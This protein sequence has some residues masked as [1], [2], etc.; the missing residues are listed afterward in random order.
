MNNLPM[1]PPGYTRGQKQ[2]TGTLDSQGGTSPSS[3]ITADGIPPKKRKLRTKI[4]L[5][6]RFVEPDPSRQDGLMR[7]TKPVEG[8]V[9]T[10][11]TTK[12]KD[13]NISVPRRSPV[14]NDYFNGQQPKNPSSTNKDKKATT[15]SQQQPIRQKWLETYAKLQSYKSQHNT[16]EINP[17]ETTDEELITLSKWITNQKNTYNKWKKGYQQTGM[18]DEKVKLLKELGMEFSLGWDDMYD[19]LV[20]HHRKN[21]K[22][23]TSVKKRNEITEK[24]D[25]LGAEYDVDIIYPQLRTNDP[26][27]YAW[28]VRQYKALGRH[29]KGHS[30]RL[31]D[32][33]AKKLLALGLGRASQKEGGDI[34]NRGG[35]KR[36]GGEKERKSSEGVKSN[37]SNSS[38][39]SRKKKKSPPPSLK[40]AGVAQSEGKQEEEE[41][42]DDDDFFAQHNDLCEVCANPG[43]LLCCSTCNLVFHLQCTRPHLNVEPPDDWSCS[44][45]IANDGEQ[46]GMLAKEKCRVAQEAIVEMECTRRVLKEK[47]DKEKIFGVDEEEKEVER[48]EVEVK[49]EQEGEEDDEMDK[50]PAAVPTPPLPLDDD[51]DT[52]FNIFQSNDEESDPIMEG[53]QMNDHVMS[54][55]AA[56]ATAAI[57]KK[58]EVPKVG[59]G[60]RVLFDKDDVYTAKIIEVNG[61]G[62]HPADGYEDEPTYD[63]RIRYDDDGVIEDVK[64]PDDDITLIPGRVG[65]IKT[66]KSAGMRAAVDGSKTS[67]N[68]P[69]A[70]TTTNPSGSRILSPGLTP[71]ASN[72]QVANYNLC[73][74]KIPSKDDP[75][76]E[77]FLTT[78]HS[79]AD[80]GLVNALHDIVRRDVFEVRRTMSGKI[81]FQCGCCKHVPRRERA[82]LSIVAPQNVATIYRSFVRFMMNHVK[83][84]KH[85][86]SSV[87]RLQCH[88]TA[89]DMRC[90]SIDSRRGGIKEYWVTSAKRLGYV[91][92]ESGKAI[93]YCPPGKV[94]PSDGMTTLSANTFKREEHRAKERVGCRQS[95][96]KRKGTQR[97][98]DR[99]LDEDNAA[100]ASPAKRPRSR[101]ECSASASMAPRSGEVKDVAN[102][103]KAKEGTSLCSTK[104]CKKHA[105]FAGVCVSHGAMQRI[106][107]TSTSS[108]ST[109]SNSLQA[110]AE[111]NQAGQKIAASTPLPEYAR[112]ERKRSPTS[113]SDIDLLPS[114]SD[115]YAAQNNHVMEVASS[116]KSYEPLNADDALED[117]LLNGS[118]NLDSFVDM[119]LDELPDP[120]K[121]EDEP[122]A[123]SADADAGADNDFAKMWLG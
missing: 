87:R 33:Q 115:E 30:T 59:M 108:N 45:C 21:K 29:L 109:S 52:Y 38:S 70:M 53:P 12:N 37:K 16:I 17:N 111:G 1:K 86:P 96:R 100:E 56:A 123:V 6:K 7:K 119:K 36:K 88:G 103:G 71:K 8:G 51:D 31:N 82:K 102:W 27:L 34:K 19:K 92:D 55:Q 20:Q 60:V 18:N 105:V 101:N 110:V 13:N 49:E 11:N 81:F 64:Y 23:V 79:A 113:V 73:N 72:S 95:G 57:G 98:L 121:G 112:K 39:L 26:N 67:R 4:K 104:G 28:T 85:L 97:F 94:A 69:S 32:E 80:A 89:Q 54:T 118:S 43:E 107:A 46:K 75:M 116:V 3:S 58:L 24:K 117:Q 114:I 14:Q 66:A 76:D 62:N 77:T 5:P 40:E 90:K 44:Y 99:D 48:L 84:C 25:V 10:K 9:A 93:L 47:R 83:F 91:D 15:T 63:I 50:K 74:G 122:L 41:V 65:G 106:Y 22:K 35:R 78:L 42:K 68:T 2:A 61:L 120:S